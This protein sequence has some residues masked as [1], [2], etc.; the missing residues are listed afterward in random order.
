MILCHNY[1]F[2]FLKTTK[3]AGTS[4]EIALSKFCGDEDIITPI[5]PKDEYIRRE[6]NYRGPQNYNY[7]VPISHLTPHDWKQIFFKGRSPRK[8]LLLRRG[9]SVNF[10]DHMSARDVK[11]YIDTSIWNEYYK[12]C[13][14]RNP[15][16]R[17]ISLYY[18]RYQNEPRPSI[19]DF[20]DSGFPSIMHERG[21]GQYTINEQIVVNKVC[22]YE[23]LKQ[24]LEEISGRLGLPE[25]LSLPM[26]KANFRK[27][28]RHYRDI[29]SN[30]D[31]D[32]IADIFH[33]EIALFGYEY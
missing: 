3:T 26:A 8:E 13:V 29:Y 7:R 6:L 25:S 28:K 17:V 24:D 23:R 20:I 33:K 19:S 31:K 15:Y 12:F 14:E 27:D 16:D 9:A 18:W 1:K 11:K 5:N 2:I 10:Y 30:G 22:L 21:F 32:K 4:I